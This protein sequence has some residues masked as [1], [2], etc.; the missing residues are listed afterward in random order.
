MRGWGTRARDVWTGAWGMAIGRK[1]SL[2]SGLAAAMAAPARAECI[3]NCGYGAA[4]AMAIAI[5]LGV[6][7]LVGFALVKLRIGWLIKWLVAA[8]VLL[9]A[10]PPLVRDWIHD[11]KQQSIES[12][13]FAGPLPRVD[14]R[15]TLF[16]IQDATSLGNCPF[17]LARYIEE[18]GFRHGV[19]L[20]ETGSLTG[21][22]FTK[23]VALADL[24]IERQ[25]MRRETVRYDQTADS[26]ETEVTDRSVLS[27]EERQAVAHRV[28]YLVMADCYMQSG[29]VAGLRLNPALQAADRPFRIELAMAP[30]QAGA[31]PLVLPELSFD[32]LDLTF[33]GSTPGFLIF[34]S[35]RYGGVH[36]AP[37]DRA[38]LQDA[39]CLLSDGTEIEHCRY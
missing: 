28:D 25:T 26:Y 29:L 31:A 36:V 11:R 38:Q 37:Y 10:V 33:A 20:V 27:A 2:A 23:P 16:L 5:G 30:R 32:L 18:T 6:L 1:L 3:Y 9:L 35:E 7:A 14:D 22:D 15:T 19:L 4:I 8:L 24:P 17:E 39:F 12:L 21:V 34:A 13:D